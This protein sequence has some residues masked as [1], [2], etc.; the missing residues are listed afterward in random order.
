L[1]TS[2]VPRASLLI[3]AIFLVL[4]IAYPANGQAAPATERGK[5]PVTEIGNTANAPGAQPTGSM[6][7]PAFDTD[8]PDIPPFAR[9]F[10]D[11]ATYLRL[12]DQHVAVRR[13]IYDLMNAP[14]ARSQAVQTMQRQEQLLRQLPLRSAQGLAAVTPS[15]IPLGPAPIPNGQT[16]SPEVP[17]S[18][19][20]TAIAIDQT[21]TTGNTVYVGTA[22]GGLYRTLDGGAT[23]TALM[24]AAQSL[25]IG[26]ITV[27][28]VNHTTVFVGT[29]EG[30]LSGDSFFGVGVYII[31]NATT[32]ANLAGPFNAPTVSPNPDGFTDVF[33]GRSINR[34][35]VNPNNDNQ[36]LV[37]TTAGFSGASFG[38]FNI[39][40]TMG[41]YFSTNA[42]SGAPT[43][44]RSSIQTAVANRVVTDM[45]MDPGNVNTIVVH[46]FGLAA[47][48]DGGVWKSTSGNPWNGTATWTQEFIDQADNGRFTA[49]RVGTTT[50]FL[51][52]LDQ[53]ATC[54]TVP[55]GGV[56]L[57]SNDG[58]AWTELP[59]ARGFCGGQC[60]YDVAVAVDPVTAN[61]IYL[62][63]AAGN[64]V[65]SCGTGILGKSTD[66]GATFGPSQNSLHA[67]SHA[68][69][70]LASN[71]AVIY[72]GND[73]GIFK[74]TDSGASWTSLNTA[75]FSATQFE[76]MSVHPIDAFFS[77]GGTQDNGSPM[78]TGA[79][80]WI[81][82]D[83]GDGGFSGIDQNLT[84]ATSV[85]MYHAYFTRT[86]S[87]IGY[88][89]ASTGTGARQGTWH[90]FGCLGTTPA[91]GITCGDTVLFYA[92]LALGPGTPNT[93]YFGTDRLYRSADGGVT[94]T[95]VS[96]AP[97]VTGIPVS[98]IGVSLQDDNV[99][100]VGLNNG[101]VFATS[102]GANPMVDVTGGW[103]AKY[104]A[105]AVID[106]SVKTTA[107]VTL[108]GYG[109]T[110]H[111]WKTTNL[112]AATPTWTATGFSI[113]VP[114]N[115]FVVDPGNSNFLY[116]GTDIGVF[117]SGDGGV[118]WNPYG[119]GLPRVAVFDMKIVPNGH[120]LRIGTHGRGAWEI[121]AAGNQ[122]FALTVSTLGTGA[123]AVTSN[124]GSINCG[125]TCTANFN[126]GTT[127]T[128]TATPAAGS[129]FTGWSGA[130]TGFQ[131]C[132]VTMSAAQS[133]TASFSLLAPGA[134]SFVP[135]TPCRI[136]DTRLANG[137]FGGPFLSGQT[138]RGFTIPSSACNIPATAQAYSLNVTVV[139][140]GPL[141]F[142]TTFPC[143]Q[144]QPLVSTL[145]S[146]DGRIKAVAAFAPAGANGAVCFF[147]T[148]DTELVLDIDGY[149][150]TAANPAGL[151]FYPVTP[152]RLVDTRL[153]A[154]ALGGP[155]LVGGVAR[156]FPLFAG[157]CNLPAAA[158][159]YSLNYTSVPQGPLGFVTTWPA[160][161]PQ[162][163]VSTL[164]APTGAITANA[165]IVPAGSSGAVSVFATNNSDMVI[166]VNGYFAPPGPGGLALFNLTPCRVLDT[167]NPPGAPPLNGAMSVNVAG[168]GCG[169]PVSAQ[170]YVLNATVVPPGSLGFLTLWPQGGAQPLVSTLNALDG[171]ITSNMALVPTT[172]GSVS[173]FTANPSH[174]VLDISGYFASPVN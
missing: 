173:A 12:R 39:L 157:P 125:V 35:L 140:H 129:L 8:G 30:S 61:N 144:A 162:P 57:K 24:D 46:V 32:T 7:A 60:F 169:A 48:G 110:S 100:I 56:L 126:P 42:L 33:T 104:I 111:I 64:T 141:G 105:R 151:A 4:A 99:R 11:E 136:A 70:I 6:E 163:L 154:G 120:T 27:D 145:N 63:G 43:F 89:S 71:P 49:N 147:V 142:L 113:D 65:G 93:V 36:I 34:I 62:G 9:N 132:T 94:H 121:P 118:T 97:F 55:V 14:Q 92:P 95:V 167:R 5:P 165:A 122:T 23:W 96:Q 53:T 69:A 143:G 149:F 58:A 15:W 47:A 106:P 172:N 67:D 72:E 123:G 77:I 29:G 116:A 153:A 159:A 54:N 168:S 156:T 91:N 82:A 161:Q 50:T 138:S 73:G 52:A 98:A 160:G 85:P 115:A 2:E 137:P 41:V 20:V 155:S 51:L 17:V 79:G 21:D 130:C 109:T 86:N 102:I 133:V 75:G 101:R 81:R 78:M 83:G 22:Q 31:T 119:T 19:R 131:G 170:S 68:I 3:S 174:V 40:P 117:F 90:F 88:A 1:T 152:C 166:D 74:S 16:G 127:V 13:G 112:S 128:L 25:A 84:S 80:T 76:S 171:A 18:G 103:A 26:A 164:N 124:D 10:I 139:P 87:Q 135:V 108:D 59:A 44:A 158:Q 146:L 134:L 148:N 107:Y 37:A 45:I 38:P 66:G 150:V 28:P 114:V